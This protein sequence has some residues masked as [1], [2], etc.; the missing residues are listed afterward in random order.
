MY[1][2]HAT[3]WQPPRVPRS[4][5]TDS[6]ILVASTAFVDLVTTVTTTTAQ[7]APTTPTTTTNTAETITTTIAATTATAPTAS[8]VVVMMVVARPRLFEMFV[9]SRF[10]GW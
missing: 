7:V 9:R 10:L 8:R 5:S 6:N 2:I 4:A 3:T 1:P